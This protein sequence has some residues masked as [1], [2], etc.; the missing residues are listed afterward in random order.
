MTGV[1]FWQRALAPDVDATQRG[2][3]GGSCGG[4]SLFQGFGVFAACILQQFLE[5]AIERD[6]EA[7]HLRFKFVAVEG[8]HGVAK[9]GLGGCPIENA[10]GL[11]PE[12]VKVEGRLHTLHK[13]Q[14]RIVN[15]FWQAL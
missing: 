5:M 1:V 3:G 12:F 15:F 10:G 8:R 4:N 11:V 9:A 6:A 2:F 13:R 14:E 7:V